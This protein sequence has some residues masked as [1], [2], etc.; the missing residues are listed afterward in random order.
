MRSDDE[1]DDSYAA[2]A[3]RKKRR[4]GRVLLILLAIVVLL[5]VV[6]DR[7]GVVIAERT[8]AT[9]VH[10]QLAG[11]DVTTTG[12]PKIVIH[13]IP[14]LTQ[15]A[16]GYY[17][18]IDIDVKDPTTR[19]VRLDTLDVTATGVRAA[20]RD[21]MSG[22]ATIRADKVVGTAHMDWSSFLKLADT[23]QLGQYGVDPDSVQI[24][25]ADDGHVNVTA[26]VTFLGAT[27]TAR[28]GGTVT[29]S[30]NRLHVKISDISAADGLIPSVVQS[31]LDAVG[32]QLNFTVA[33]PPLPYN[34]VLDSVRTT[35]AGVTITASAMDVVLG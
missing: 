18:R 34:L 10:Q 21:L 33:I 5:V 25:G 8:V 30:D 15:V 12:D 7:V 11:Q 17:D 6:A 35:A 31:R 4:V 9:Q 23:S 28:A 3:P 27:F 2:P 13:G 20:A 32:R 16:A 14:F 29:V 1:F 26:P 22:H 19:G 24:S